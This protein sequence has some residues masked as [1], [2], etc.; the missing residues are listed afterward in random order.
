MVLASVRGTSRLSARLGWKVSFPQFR[1]GPKAT[2]Y[3]CGEEFKK[4]LRYGSLVRHLATV[5]IFSKKVNLL[6]AYCTRWPSTSDVTVAVLVTALSDLSRGAFVQK[7]RPV[8]DTQ[9][10]NKKH[11]ARCVP[12]AC[13]R[14]CVRARSCVCVCGCS[15]VAD[16]CMQQIP[17]KWGCF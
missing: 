8:R 16:R 14:A 15:V 6:C 3:L 13:M 2:S 4:Q 11:T 7:R 10:Y 17:W 5:P 1:T 9:S 12:C